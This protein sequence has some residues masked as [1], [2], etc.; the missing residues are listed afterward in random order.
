MPRTNLSRIY[1]PSRRVD[2]LGLLPGFF[3]GLSPHVLFLYSV[4][5]LGKRRCGRLSVPDEQRLNQHTSWT[6]TASRP[7]GL[8]GHH[9]IPRSR[10]VRPSGAPGVGSGSSHTSAPVSSG[11]RHQPVLIGFCEGPA[12]FRV[13]SV[14]I[15]FVMCE[16]LAR[17]HSILVSRY[18]RVRRA[19]PIDAYKYDVALA[20]IL[21]W[22]LLI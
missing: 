21:D 20:Q 9:L 5:L 16:T 17:H 3:A 4:L 14:R 6:T 15:T 7:Y 18:R 10:F 12:A 13:P 2:A 19:S 1:G 8:P 22:P 11:S